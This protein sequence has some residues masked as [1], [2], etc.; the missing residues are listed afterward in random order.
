MDHVKDF[1]N[2]R[3]ERMARRGKDLRF[4]YDRPS[5]DYDWITINGVH[6]PIDD[7][8]NIAGGA[9]GKFTG[10]KYTGTKMQRSKKRA[11]KTSGGGLS[12][13]ATVRKHSDH[14]EKRLEAWKKKNKG[15]EPD[16]DA[17]HTISCD[18]YR[19]A[20]RDFKR[21]REEFN[22][23]SAY[24]GGNLA[25]AVAEHERA[26]EHLEKEM[27]EDTSGATGYKRSIE[28]YKRIIERTKED[29]NYESDKKVYDK[30][31]A[32]ASALEEA[33]VDASE[34]MYN[35]GEN[36]KNASEAKAYL[37]AS[38]WLT[39]YNTSFMLRFNRNSL[40]DINISKGSMK[41]IASI[42]NAVEAYKTDFPNMKEVIGGLGIVPMKDN[43]Y[44]H[45][46]YGNTVELSEKY[47]E[48]QRLNGFDAKS[49]YEHDVKSGF[50]PKGTTLYSVAYHEIAHA[51]DH[52]MVSN[53]KKGVLQGA[54]PS[55]VVFKRVFEKLGGG[56]YE[57]EFK[58]SVSRY[59]ERTYPSDP[60]Q[61]YVEFF[62]E[63]MC[64][65]Y[66]SENPRDVARA[67]REEF[68][69]LYHEIYG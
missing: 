28:Q 38:G 16:K 21:E 35:K 65:A 37:E 33:R 53:D 12:T 18:A 42:T 56:R 55:E 57:E 69:N 62:A 17:L 40:S 5:D 9:G 14:F 30:M 3:N 68:T 23:C 22:K 48:P 11:T 44:G 6:T 26:I 32:A 27:A 36:F 52:K 1:Y 58:E 63:A 19:E 29:S 43:S 39:T 41:S 66:C 64:E 34:Y 25:L 50:H 51:M 20:F 49:E 61:D 8:G 67:V 13:A 2:R 15:N 4:D 46:K 10:K 7:A 60:K 24:S 45:C 54:M 47:F 31:M 59:A